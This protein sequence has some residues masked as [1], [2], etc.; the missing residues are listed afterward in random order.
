MTFPEN[1]IF[2]GFPDPEG[3]LGS[4]VSNDHF[5]RH[6]VGSLLVSHGDSNMWPGGLLQAIVHSPE[7]LHCNWV[8]KH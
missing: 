4:F 6:R 3:T 7:Q 2:P 5:S 1:F 8:P